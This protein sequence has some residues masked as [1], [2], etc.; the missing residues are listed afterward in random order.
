MKHIR[1]L[2]SRPVLVIFIAAI[3]VTLMIGWC[4]YDIMRIS[5][6][7]QPI[8]V[9]QAAY[10]QAPM[11][12]FRTLI[13][14]Y[15]FWNAASQLGDERHLLALLTL[16]IFTP[17]LLGW[18]HAPLL[19]V[20]P[21][22]LIFL[23]LFG[24]TIYKRT[25]HLGYS[26]AAILFFCAIA[27]LTRHT[28]GIGSGFAD[29]Q[30]M[31]FLSAAALSLINA[32]KEPGTGWIR[33]FTVLVSLAVLA[34]T[35]SMFYA[36]VICG[37]MVLLYLVA[38]YRRE[39]SLK[40]PVAT[41]LNIIVIIAPVAA[42]VIGQL[43]RMF[44]YYGSVNA[45]NLHQPFLASA[46]NIFFRLLAPFLGF[47]F[48]VLCMSLFL[49]NILKQTSGFPA[50][51]RTVGAVTGF[52]EVA[53]GW[54]IVGFL[55]FLLAN[56]YTS[57]V[58]KEA[59]YVTPALMLAALTPLRN[60]DG[61][62][63]PYYGYLS[64][65]LAALSLVCFGYFSY[66]NAAFAR[67]I[68]PEQA[69]FKKIQSDMARELAKLPSGI[70]WQSYASIDWG[71]PV[72]L[73]TQYEFGEY[74]QYGG[75]PFYN[76]KAYWDTWYPNRSLS[77]LQDELYAQAANCVDAAVILKDP[78]RQPDGMEDYSYAIAA[79]IARSVKADPNWSLVASVDGWPEGARYQIFWNDAPASTCNCKP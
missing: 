45:W 48:V 6:I 75:T 53:I 65:G 71:I 73:I 40:K 64:V 47:P 5:R 27:Q 68:T 50:H 39:R 12:A 4:A 33:A 63:L 23:A 69:A 58:P 26:L 16:G 1:S 20:L 38:Q 22:L 79:H 51:R 31:L 46:N 17:S 59:M 19:V 56:G 8:W 72:S 77:E 21:A 37:P 28:K 70:T 29:W 10:G 15:G 2:S 62:A 34:R 76:K 55:G 43:A 13:E 49:F 61:T 30:S 9:E 54:W 11:L 32:L 14:K 60:F 24:W 67:E 78:D 42:V 18:F 44:L 66:Q 7:V 74:R 52:S 3:G 25:S 57:D 35:T 36:A 41:L